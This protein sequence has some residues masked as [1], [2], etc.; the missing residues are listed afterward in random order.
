M[1]ARTLGPK[2]DRYPAFVQ[3]K[4]N[5][6]RC[7]YDNGVFQSRGEEVWREFV[8]HHILAEFRNVVPTINE[9]VLDGELY[10]HG[11]RLSH[12]N[13]AVAVERSSPRDDT[14]LVEYH[15]FDAVHKIRGYNEGFTQRFMEEASYLIEAANQPHIKIV[16]SGFVDNFQFTSLMFDK[17]VAEGYEGIMVRP[18]NGPYELGVHVVDGQERE[19]RSTSLWKYK[20]WTDGEWLCVDVTQGDGKAAIGIGALV[21]Q[22]DTGERF[23]CGTGFDDLDRIEL[24]KNPPIGKMVKARYNFL[25]ERG[26]PT[27]C[28]Y[29]CVVLA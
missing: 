6:V 25:S 2:F 3:P 11:W 24:A 7:L 13:G 12:I 22:T 23:N 15:I 10:V 16:P 21:L 19:F 18:I 27:P 1:L 8:L 26:I 4:L 29:L 20:S 9:Y 14:H 5:G 28:S 17:F